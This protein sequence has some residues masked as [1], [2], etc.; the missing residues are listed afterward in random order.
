MR[1]LTHQPLP[2]IQSCIDLH[3]NAAKLTN[4]NVVCVGISVNTSGLINEEERQTYLSDIESITGLPAIDPVIDGV[5]AI[6]KTMD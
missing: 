5:A 2:D 3:I 6:T 1:G 4:S